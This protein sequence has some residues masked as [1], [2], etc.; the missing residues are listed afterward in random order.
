[1]RF[2]S[3]ILLLLLS[4]VTMKLQWG[5]MWNLVIRILLL[6]WLVKRVCHCR[7]SSE[8]RWSL[9]CLFRSFILLE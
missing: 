5:G 6:V 8:I 1:L 9:L 2:W 7:C 3:W 4:R